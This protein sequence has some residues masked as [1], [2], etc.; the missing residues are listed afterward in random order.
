MV[1]VSSRFFAVDDN[2]KSQ[3]KVQSQRLQRNEA[4]E[5]LDCRDC[6]VHVSSKLEAKLLNFQTPDA[7]DERG[8]TAAW[9]VH[10]HKALQ[11]ASGVWRAD[12][13]AHSLHSLCRPVG[14]VI[15]PSSRL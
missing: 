10:L 4:K 1:K 8:E 11:V 6:R 3:P 7:A 15:W 5:S 12:L 2:G 9:K 13:L 14:A